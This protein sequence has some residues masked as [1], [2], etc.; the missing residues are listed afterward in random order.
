[1]FTPLSTNTDANGSV[2]VSTIEASELP[3]YAAQYH[4]ERPQWEWGP[5]TAEHL[6]INHGAPSL[7]AVWTGIYIEWQS[8]FWSKFRSKF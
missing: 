7:A 6:A 4:P 5:P 3:I 1:M 8:N 2:F